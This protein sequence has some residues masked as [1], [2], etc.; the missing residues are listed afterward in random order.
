MVVQLVSML[1]IKCGD[2]ALIEK[3][4]NQYGVQIRKYENASSTVPVAQWISALD[5]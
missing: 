5:F 3:A 2:V 4:S 1:K